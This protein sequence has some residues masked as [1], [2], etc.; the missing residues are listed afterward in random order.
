MP[1]RD[2]S[3]HLDFLLRGPQELPTVWSENSE[4]SR[5]IQLRYPKTIVAFIQLGLLATP[6]L[7][8][9]FHIVRDQPSCGWDALVGD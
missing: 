7:A 9:R 8:F 2:F 4:D 3:E 6:S 1:M 5:R